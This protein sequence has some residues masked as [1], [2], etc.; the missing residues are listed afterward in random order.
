MH[1]FTI[2]IGLS[3]ALISRAFVRPTPLTWNL[4]W[5]KALFL[6]IFPPLLLLSSSVALI[7]M[8]PTGAMVGYWE[9]WLSYILALIFL[10]IAIVCWCQ[11]CWQG[12]KTFQNIQHYAQIQINGEIARLIDLS[13]PYSA[14]MGFWHSELVVSQGLLDRLEESHLRAIIAHERAHGYYRDTFWF[15]WLG[16]LRRFTSWLPH[17]NW[18][19][20]E[21]L[22]LRE[23]RADRYAL[24]LVEPLM[25][26]ETLLLMVNT[27][28]EQEEFFSAAFSAIAP[29]HRLEQ[30]INAILTPEETI[31]SS[32]Q[33]LSFLT[34]LFLLLLI[35][36]HR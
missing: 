26:A 16:W 15:F 27:S 33:I 2:A 14:R 20:Q 1:W 11:C 3:L 12:L 30:R 29:P 24:D 6:F 4:R 18:L 17:T 9:G 19:W 36:F 31:E 21:L 23:I 35:P 8:G 10:A 13:I 32:Y 25:L 28:F 22:M 7:W 5:Q 34:A